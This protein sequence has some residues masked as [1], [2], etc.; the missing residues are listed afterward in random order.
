V[1]IQYNTRP[2]RFNNTT[3]KKADYRLHTKKKKP[4]EQNALSD[5]AIAKV[6]P[7]TDNSRL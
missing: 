1:D 5:T 4:V 6:P 3:G 7:L 2:Y